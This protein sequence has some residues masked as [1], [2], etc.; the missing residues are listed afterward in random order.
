M[1]TKFHILLE[2]I[3]A[4]APSG[5]YNYS[6]KKPGA[7]Y[8]R[9]NSSL[10]TAV[11]KFDNFSGSVVLQASLM[12]N[13]EETDWV[14]ITDTSS[15]GGDSTSVGGDSTVIGTQNVTRNFSGNFAWIRC[16]YH[17]DNGTI[18]QITFGF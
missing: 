17:I 13:P 11:Y 15:G 3:S 18:T 6:D 8:S 10:H 16:K 9:R 7:G 4:A 2:N 12:R 5:E 1:A 14:D